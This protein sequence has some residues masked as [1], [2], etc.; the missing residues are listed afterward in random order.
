[1]IYLNFLCVFVP[2][3]RT[4]HVAFG[5]RKLG[6]NRFRERSFRIPDVSLFSNSLELSTLQLILNV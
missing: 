2:E 5:A 3:A 1:M 6:W 4:N